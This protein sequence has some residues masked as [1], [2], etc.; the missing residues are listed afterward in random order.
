MQADLKTYPLLICGINRKNGVL[1]SQIRSSPF[2]LKLF[3]DLG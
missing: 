1:G 3:C 2:V